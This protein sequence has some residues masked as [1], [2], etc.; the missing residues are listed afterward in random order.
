MATRIARASARSP[1]I[2]LRM[3][4]GVA[5][6][7]SAAALLGAAL[8]L[9]A[10]AGDRTT[11][12]ARHAHG[13]SMGFH[14]SSSGSADLQYAIIESG[15][16]TTCSVSDDDAWRVIG[17]L[18]KEVESSGHELIWF[19]L[20]GKDYA[21]RDEAVIERAREIVRPMNELGRQQGRLGS[22]QGELGRRQGELGRIQGRIGEL[23]GRFARLQA[24][25][26]SESRTE[27]EDLRQQLEGLRSDARDL[28][29]RQ[30][31]L[32]A[33][34]RE[35]GARQRELGERQRIASKEAMTRLR[36]LAE[37]A[38]KS[39]KADRITD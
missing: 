25:S 39:G 3:G 1:I 17:T 16:N 6:A 12:P 30:R 28:G 14:V 34:Q 37:D 26:S 19:A 10:A 29:E 5:L 32:G 13:Y 2:G 18:Q 27:I 31:E 15:N 35:L 7:A 4:V 23:Q 22:E 21:V 33:Q 36:S 9:P 24:T 8:A 38:V 11:S 20:D